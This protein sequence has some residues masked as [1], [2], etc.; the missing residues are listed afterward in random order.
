MD[1][2]D[3]NV[4]QLSLEILKNQLLPF[5]QNELVMFYGIDWQ[6]KLQNDPIIER[7][8]IEEIYNEKLFYKNSDIRNL[9]LVFSHQWERIFKKNYNND[10]PLHL[11]EI[12]LYHYNQYVYEYKFNFRETYKIIEN[13]QTFME[14]LNFNVLEINLVRL[15]MLLYLASDTFN[16]TN[17]STDVRNQITNPNTNT[18]QIYKMYFKA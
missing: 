1:N 9:L 13:I 15:D 7:Y 14:E 2:Y 16:L 8:L 6:I 17:I 12:V 11:C 3:R 10:Y 5:V 18:T 4:V